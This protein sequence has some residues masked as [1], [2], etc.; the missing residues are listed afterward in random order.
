MSTPSLNAS[1]IHYAYQ[2]KKVLH[3]ANLALDPGQVVSLLGAN[4][5]GKSTL[6]RIALGL[7]QPQTGEVHLGGRLLHA[8]PRRELARHL[9][10]VP[11]VHAMPFPY[12]VRQVVLMG[13]LPAIGMFGAPG[14]RDHDIAEQAMDRL[15]IGRLAD[16]PYT[17]VSGGER[18]MALIA[19]ALAQG[20]RLLI[21]DEPATGLDYGN[22][23]ALL[24]LLRT[25]AA[26]GYGIL[27]TTHHPDHVL[28]SSDRVAILQ[29]GRI[30]AAG[31]PAEVMSAALLSDLYGV[32]IAPTR[33]PDGRTV[34]LP[35]PAGGCPIPP[36]SLS[37][38]KELHE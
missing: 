6:L 12:T 25:L 2:G 1:N 9:A 34:I 13:R 17:E 5:A 36:V 28:A 16:R 11:Q 18:Q 30:V 8:Y 24:D 4:G 27:K 7:L 33:L 29:G 37:A 35:V 23:I 20:S 31:P 38:S 26:D 10:Y 19:R 32:A 15:G 3:G 22:Q 21:L 14:R